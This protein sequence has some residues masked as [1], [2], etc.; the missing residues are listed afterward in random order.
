MPMRPLCVALAA[1]LVFSGCG[2]PKSDVPPNSQETPN[3][4][5]QE[6]KEKPAVRVAALK[7]PTAIGMLNLMESSDKG[8]AANTYTFTLA[9]APDEIVGKVATG[10]VDIAAVPT[11]LASVL[12]AKTK[13]QVQLAALNTLGVLYIVETGD[14]VHSVADLEGKTIAATGQ[15]ATPEYALNLILEKNGLKAGETVTV[16]YKQEH[17]EIAPLLASGQVEIALLPQPFVTSL[18]AQNENVRVALDVTQEWDKAVEGASQLTMG[19][20]VVRREFAEKHPDLVVDWLD[21]Y[22][23][24][25]EMMKNDPAGSVEPLLSYFNDYCGLEL[26]RDMV[27]KEF[28]YRYLFDVNEQIA[29]ME[30]PAR[31]PAWLRGVADF[32]LEQGRISQKEYDRYAQANFHIDPSFMKK[33]A[34]RRAAAR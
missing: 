11:N 3:T 32:M 20:L 8:E 27:E 2:A 18:L 13:G 21:V 12:Y 34:E 29:A 10:E 25:V 14:A 22:M 33:L 15:N 26:S 6:E 31:L 17:A 4:Q 24:G 7:G 5:P 1:A 30:D 16:E 23:R 9:G 19:A 28:K